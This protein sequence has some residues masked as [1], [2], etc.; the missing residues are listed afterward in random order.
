MLLRRLYKLGISFVMVTLAAMSNAIAEPQTVTIVDAEGSALKDAVLIRF[1]TDND[2]R[3]V[4]KQHIMDQVNRQFSP[5]LL[6]IQQGDLV[7]F[8]NSDNV[9]HHVYSFS[10]P[11][12]F[13]L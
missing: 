10:K 8:P 12:V 2:R 13:E 4:P 9:R 6:V 7:A 3:Q 1:T 5:Q 11:K